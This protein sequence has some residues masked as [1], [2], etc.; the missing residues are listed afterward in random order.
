ML[1]LY[2]ATGS[3]QYA[4]CQ[5]PERPQSFPASARLLNLGLV[6]ESAQKF[7]LRLPVEMRVS[8]AANQ[9]S[10][11]GWAVVNLKT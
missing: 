4:K 5:L 7:A 9:T 10:E 8:F 2:A 11:S 1:L 6:S 3:M